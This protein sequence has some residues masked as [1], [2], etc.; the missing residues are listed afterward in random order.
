MENC[1]TIGKIFFPISLK[2]KEG[3]KFLPI[4]EECSR[5]MYCVNVG[6]DLGLLYPPP[7]LLPGGG[8]TPLLHASVFLRMKAL[9]TNCVIN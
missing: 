2:S 8:Y 5:G 4:L 9:T 1:N 6:G 7:L 3:V